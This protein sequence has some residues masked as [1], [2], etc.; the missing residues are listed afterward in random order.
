MPHGAS[1]G[2]WDE[3]ERRKSQAVRAGVR[4]LH[5]DPPTVARVASSR[6]VLGW[7]SVTL[8]SAEPRGARL[9]DYDRIC[10]CLLFAVRPVFCVRA[11]VN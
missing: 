6:Q 9:A 2:D 3:V 10:V 4:L 7:S 8:T 11:C 5:V 1:P